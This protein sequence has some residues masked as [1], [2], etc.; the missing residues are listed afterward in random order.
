MSGGYD[1]ALT[2]FSPNGQLFQ[3][4]Y[5][6]EA[7][8]QGTAVVGVKSADVAVL[9]VER[10]TVASLQD[11]R[12]IRKV[13]P[14]DAH[15]HLAYSGLNADGR[16]LVDMARVECQSYRLSCEDAPSIEYV[17]RYVAQVQQKYTHKGGARP[18]GV[19]AMLIGPDEHGNPKLFQTDPS[20]VY[21]SYKATAIGRN[22]KTI[23]DFLEKKY[24]EGADAD[25]S[26]SL[27]LRAIMQ[28][29][30]PKSVE[31]YVFARNATG[32]R[33]IPDEEVLEIAK[34]ITELEEQES[35]K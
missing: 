30:D 21:F 12:T 6:L 20:G 25:A 19:S 18:F 34:K 1:R 16:V 28:I 9:A 7:V 35:K 4:E 8:K 23:T 27:A 13:V 22:S 33:Q 2:V 11:A 17:T 31:L 14:V 32:P 10:K 15:I 3:V 24:A 29:V 26:I 5:A